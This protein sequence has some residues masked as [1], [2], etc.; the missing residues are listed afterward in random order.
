MTWLRAAVALLGVAVVVAVAWM[1]TQRATGGRPDAG[2]P[3]ERVP[4]TVEVLNGTDVDG[5]ARRAT[6]HLRRAGLDVVFYGTSAESADSTTIIVRGTDPA[7]GDVVRYA[8]GVG[9][10]RLD[11]DPRLLLDVT[12]VVG[13]DAVAVLDRGP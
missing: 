5:L 12:V 11:P 8:L 1:L 3:G 2:V 7:A 10:I 13:R 4:F 6:L 9:R